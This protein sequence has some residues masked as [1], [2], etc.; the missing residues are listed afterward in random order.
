MDSFE[1]KDKSEILQYEGALDGNG[2]EIWKRHH[3]VVIVFVCAGRRGSRSFTRDRRLGRFFCE[4]VSPCNITSCIH[5]AS[6]MCLLKHEKNKDD[7]N[8][9]IQVDRN[10]PMRLQ[11]YMKN[12]RQTMADGSR[13]EGS[14]S[15][16]ITPTFCPVLN[17]QPWNIHIRGIIQT[18]Q[19]VLENI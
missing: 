15:G 1:N 9:S 4:H 7:S 6:C 8:T 16:R 3:T 14:S 11:P 5:K 2:C 12:Y 10:K 17:G 18:E 19:L 13:R